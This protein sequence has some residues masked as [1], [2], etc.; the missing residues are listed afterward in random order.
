MFQYFMISM[1]IAP[2]L[3]GIMAASDD[4]RKHARRNLQI[5]WTVYAVVWFFT[6]YYLRHRWR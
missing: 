5:C 3:L 4:N 6:L 2:T 1:V